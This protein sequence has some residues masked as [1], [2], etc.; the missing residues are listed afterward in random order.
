MIR[1]CSKKEQS[2]LPTSICDYPLDKLKNA[3]FIL[4]T[5]VGLCFA[6]MFVL[7][8]AMVVSVSFIKSSE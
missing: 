8:I 1:I 3:L 6:I 7:P 2:T 5:N 4:S